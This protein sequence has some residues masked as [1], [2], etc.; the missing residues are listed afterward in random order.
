[1]AQG[2][3]KITHGFE[4]ASSFNLEESESVLRDPDSNLMPVNS[5]YVEFNFSF[6]NLAHARYSDMVNIR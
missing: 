4:W 3:P 6:M 1:M 5:R 2:P